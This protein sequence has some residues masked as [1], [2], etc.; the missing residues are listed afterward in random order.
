MLFDLKKLRE[1]GWMQMWRFTAEKELMSL[2]SVS[3]ADQVSLI[4][5]VCMVVR[6]GVR[7]LSI[8]FLS[9]PGYMTVTPYADCVFFQL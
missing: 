5:F 1:L 7:A 8:M 3:L 9:L 2:L 6:N 4:V